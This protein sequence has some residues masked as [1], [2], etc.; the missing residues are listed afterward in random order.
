MAAPA[1]GRRIIWVQI[2]SHLTEWRGRRAAL[3]VAQDITERRR[4]EEALRATEE[5]FRTAFEDAPFGMCLTALD[6]HFLQANAA[7][8]EMVGYSQ[9]ELKAGAWQAI[10]HPDDLERSRQAAYQLMGS[11]ATSL[12]FEKRYIHKF[13]A[14]V[15][16]RLKISAVINDRQQPSHYI[17]HVEDITERKL[18]EQELVKAKEAAEAASRAKSEFLANMSHEIR[19]PMNGIIGMTELA[20]DTELATSSATTSIRCG[21]QANRC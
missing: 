18:A 21:P 19:T 20:L 10:T 4:S 12:E 17:T 5:L 3:V 9:Q 11:P 15:S 8:C 6:G 13:G 2:A 14:V 7:F 1:E 16:V